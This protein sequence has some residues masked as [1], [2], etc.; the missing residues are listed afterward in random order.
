MPLPSRNTQSGQSRSSTSPV[1]LLIGRR[2]CAY[3]RAQLMP[4]DM[5][6][7]LKLLGLVDDEADLTSAGRQW[8]SD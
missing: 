7:R 3:D 8:L 1:D 6:E 2:R 4:L 5:H